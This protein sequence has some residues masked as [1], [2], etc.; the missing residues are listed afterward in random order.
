MVAGY[1]IRGNIFNDINK[2]LRMDA[3]EP[4]IPNARIDSTGGTIAIN[5][6]AY[7]IQDLKEGT[8]LI[9]YIT[10]LP[11]GYYLLHPKPPVL[12]VTVGTA[13]NIVD[14]TTGGRCVPN[15]IEDLNF[16]ISDSWP[17]VQT[18]GLDQRND[19]GISNRLPAATSCGGGSFAS[20][21]TATFTSPGIIF[22]GD[23]SSDFGQGAPSSTNRVVGGISYPE[24]YRDN[25]PLITSTNS[26]QA[27]AAKAGTPVTPLDSFGPCR[28][29]ASSCNLQGLQRGFYHTSGDIRID[30][31]ANFNNGNY[32]IVADGT[33]TI[34]NSASISVTQGSTAIFSAGGD[35]VIDPSI[36]A[37]ANTCPAPAGQ[38]QGI[39]SADRD[40][41]MQGNNGDCTLPADRMLNIDGVLIAN[42]GRGGGRLQNQRDLCAAN[43][44]YPYLT[45]TAR[46]DFI[47]NA[48]GI[49]LKQHGISYEEIP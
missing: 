5:N 14:P 34:T 40:I 23:G 27:A 31:S 36:R 37:A 41:I 47:L 20:G 29:P 17:W 48:P 10:P 12:Q 49:L 16:S 7:E 39:F 6:G 13:C 28:N 25:K 4:V 35:I 26:L 1:T 33:I 18:Y 32:V 24:V 11:N 9:S 43:R 15:G 45:V 22:S 8:Y 2:N 19:N 3:G 46:P 30:R 38:L 21:T 42:A 44:S